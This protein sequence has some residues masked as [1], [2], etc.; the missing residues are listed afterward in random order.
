MATSCHFIFKSCLLL[1]TLQ[2]LF[3]YHLAKPFAVFPYS[4]ETHSFVRKGGPCG[5]VSNFLCF[6]LF[7]YLIIYIYIFFF[8]LKICTQIYIYIYIYLFILYIRTRISTS[9]TS[10]VQ[11]YHFN[12]QVSTTNSSIQKVGSINAHGF[13]KQHNQKNNQLS[14]APQNTCYAKKLRELIAG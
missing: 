11:T 13:H 10:L 6:A 3:R 12:L 8:S 4:C 1:L 7:I 2:T 9:C 14:E 5:R